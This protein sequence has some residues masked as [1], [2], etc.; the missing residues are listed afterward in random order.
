MGIFIYNMKNKKGVMTDLMKYIEW[1]VFLG[2][3]LLI[4][5]GLF[6]RFS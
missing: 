4:A 3:A 5:Y 2:L 1:A 6:R